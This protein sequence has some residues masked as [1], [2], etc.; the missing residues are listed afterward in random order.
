MGWDPQQTDT[1]LS[2]P[3]WGGC[4][5]PAQHRL[6]A[7]AAGAGGTT[8]REGTRCLTCLTS[9]LLLQ[10]PRPVPPLTSPSP[11]PAALP[12][13]LRAQC[14]YPSTLLPGWAGPCRRL[15]AG[16]RSQV[17]RQH[18]RFGSSAAP[19]LVDLSPDGCRGARAER[20][21]SGVTWTSCARSTCLAPAVRRGVGAQLPPGPQGT[22][23]T[24]PH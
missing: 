24:H 16:Q 1:D 10:P 18:L 6:W 21:P 15:H 11:A 12:A 4:S 23:Q 22:A 3:Q 17:P 14:R 2:V 5:P 8:A 20:S 19:G 9:I 13:E 7:S